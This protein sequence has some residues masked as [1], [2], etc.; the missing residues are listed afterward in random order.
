MS[1]IPDDAARL[2]DQALACEAFGSIVEAVRYWTAAII[3]AEHSPTS[4]KPVDVAWMRRRLLFA[5]SL[6]DQQVGWRGRAQ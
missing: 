3:A 4:S 5:Q 2:R 6:L 1:N